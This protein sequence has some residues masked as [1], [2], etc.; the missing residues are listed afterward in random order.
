MIE[1]LDADRPET[2]IAE[3]AAR[4]HDA[5]NWRKLLSLLS[6]EHK[7]ASPEQIVMLIREAQGARDEA[8]S[9]RNDTDFAQG[10]KDACA[11][12]LRGDVGATWIEATPEVIEALKIAEAVRR[13]GIMYSLHKSPAFWYLCHGA[14]FTAECDKY[15][16]EELIELALAILADTET[17]KPCAS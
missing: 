1:T 15:C 4:R 12:L 17:F 10:I 7:H 13:L 16:H 2:T 11:E 3:M 14:K 8:L 9:S 5:A 6:H